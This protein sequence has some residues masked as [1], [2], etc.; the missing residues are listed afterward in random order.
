[1]IEQPHRMRSVAGAL[2]HQLGVLLGIVLVCLLVGV[3]LVVFLAPSYQAE[4]VLLVD[5]RW[6]GAQD[7][8]SA[9]LASDTL[10]RLYIAEA[11]SRPLLQ[12][13][14]SKN[15]L[16]ES[17]D[18]LSKSVSASTVRGTTL[19]AIDAKSASPTEAATIANA[20]A[21][22][23][24]D[25][26]QREVTARFESTRTYLQSEL[27]RLD[28]LIKAA[29]AEKP[30]ANNPAA[31]ADHSAALGQLHNQ[32]AAI[33]TQLQDVALAE[34]RGIATLSVSALAAPPARPTNPDPLRY[35]LGAL[36]VGLALGVLAALLAERFDDRVYTARGLADAAGTPVAVIVPGGATSAGAGGPMTAYALALASLRAKHPD[37]R[38]LMVAAASARDRADVP[39]TGIG[40]AAAHDG[41]RVIIIR[42]DSDRSGIPF[43]P[44]NN[45][46]T[47]VPLPS[48]TDPRVALGALTQGSGPYDFTVLSV[49]SPGS[50][51]LAISL[52]GTAKLAIL[53]ATAKHTRHAEVRA[54]AESLRHAGV[55]VAASMLMPRPTRIPEDLPG[56]Q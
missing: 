37:A 12:E 26:N 14:V 53:V 17:V 13:V 1:M 16:A 33:Y 7:P 27:T 25:R 20:V 54:A 51:P 39:A 31:V 41:Q 45:G 44:S 8:N 56:K 9:L 47:V 10:T 43:P 30:A 34:Q 11:T 29:Q 6:A 4:A 35:L 48:S 15:N 55:E 2:R 32:Y 36:V 22:A 49:P 42:A 40:K 5:A 28:T 19:L 21:Q 23:V 52:A 50:S 3:G 18:H 24:V 46:V 38:S